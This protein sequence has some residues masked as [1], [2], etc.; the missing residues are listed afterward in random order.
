VENKINLI[1]PLEFTDS[2]KGIN[3]DAKKAKDF[4]PKLYIPSED[5]EGYFHELVKN[6]IEARDGNHKVRKKLGEYLLSN[7][8]QDELYRDV[9]HFLGYEERDISKKIIKKKISDAVIGSAFQ[10][11]ID[12][13]I[14]H[15]K[16]TPHY[17]DAKNGQFKYLN[18]SEHGFFNIWP[19]EK[20]GVQSSCF[21]KNK[22][23]FIQDAVADLRFR[24]KINFKTHSKKGK[25]LYSSSCSFQELELKNSSGTSINSFYTRPPLLISPWAFGKGKK[26]FESFFLE[27]NKIECA[28]NLY[29][30]TFSKVKKNNL[31]SKELKLNDLSIG[32]SSFKVELNSDA[33]PKRIRFLAFQLISRPITSKDLILDAQW[34]KL[35]K[36]A[37]RQ[38][39]NSP[40]Y[41]NRYFYD[42]LKESKNAWDFKF[43]NT[44]ANRKKLHQFFSKSNFKTEHW[45]TSDADE[46]SLRSLGGNDFLV[47][48]DFIINIGIFFRHLNFPVEDITAFKGICFRTITNPKHINDVIYNTIVK[49][50][51][52][53]NHEYT[54][55]HKKEY[56]KILSIVKKYEKPVDPNESFT[57]AK[58]ILG[59]MTEELREKAIKLEGARSGG[60]FFEDLRFSKVRKIF[61][62]EDPVLPHKIRLLQARIWNIVREKLYIE[63][64]EMLGIGVGSV[65]PNRL[66]EERE[67]YKFS[68]QHH[69]NYSLDNI[70]DILR[71]KNAKQLKEVSEWLSAEQLHFS[72][73]YFKNFEKHP[74]A[75]LLKNKKVFQKFKKIKKNRVID[76]FEQAYK[77]FMSAPR[78]G[79]LAPTKIMQDLYKKYDIEVSKAKKE[80]SK[81]HKDLPTELGREKLNTLGPWFNKNW[82]GLSKHH[83]PAEEFVKK[84]LMMKELGIKKKVGFPGQR[85]PLIRYTT[86]SY[87]SNGKQL[88]IM[89]KAYDVAIKNKINIDDLIVDIRRWLAEEENNYINVSTDPGYKAWQKFRKT[90]ESQSWFYYPDY[91]SSS[92]NR[93][94]N[95]KNMYK[96]SWDQ[97]L[98]S[99]ITQMMNLIK[100]DDGLVSFFDAEIDQRKWR[101]NKELP[102]KD[103][104]LE[105]QQN[106]NLVLEK[107][108]VYAIMQHHL[109]INKSFYG[110][111]DSL[112]RIVLF[113]EG[114]NPY[115]V[116]SDFM[117]QPFSLIDG[118]GNKD[119]PGFSDKIP[120]KE[121][122]DEAAKADIKSIIN[123]YEK[124]LTDLI[125]HFDNFRKDKLEVS[126]LSYTKNNLGTILSCWEV[127]NHFKALKKYI[128]ILCKYD[129]YDLRKNEDEVD[130]YIPKDEAN[131]L[132]R[133]SNK[134]SS[135]NNLLDLK[136]YLKKNKTPN[137]QNNNKYRELTKLIRDEP[138]IKK[139]KIRGEDYIERQGFILWMRARSGY[140]GLND[141]KFSEYVKKHLS[142]E[143][144][145]KVEKEFY[146]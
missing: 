30:S 32:K 67:D 38:K 6:I 14:R 5:P 31:Y 73:S 50:I 138:L 127:L 47:T 18:I 145:V 132:I 68:Q 36:R 137:F 128:K 52:E 28:E 51:K 70:E 34:I 124:V 33:L 19:S 17:E 10:G 85:N 96:D 118:D 104:N 61:S 66:K 7:N 56:S 84:F 141:L 100:T 16:N 82:R 81:L 80:A 53:L 23:L 105:K 55:I 2:I 99:A 89:K 65:S 24:G 143:S 135:I 136:D 90:K 93:L 59:S 25:R 45:G 64:S 94:F 140:R 49:N 12:F 108:R 4:Y 97:Q 74:H 71:A 146:E 92:L 69:I 37:R 8:F 46:D 26:Q 83:M 9:G 88:K 131:L 123:F 130:K 119:L 11:D 107:V 112:L 48:G 109:N 116:R 75:S 134:T 77:R 13:D 22:K 120:Y 42:Q 27:S 139:Y 113:I 114:L 103:S 35:D 125:N 91:L 1:D 144:L 3:K 43:K 95:L 41:K 142:M 98:I 39:I 101:I 62:A 86:I 29:K 15:L 20:K 121:K 87:E 76:L 126:S 117:S 129:L 111:G 102:K 60:S 57:I 79:G 21:I 54:M 72:Q 78:D 44:A 133:K 63:P 58:G 122:I 115:D 40:G 110:V 106:L